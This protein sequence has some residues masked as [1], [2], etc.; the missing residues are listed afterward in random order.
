M[1]VGTDGVLLGAW[2]P[3][4]SEHVSK[5][6]VPT[7]LD[8]GTGS[9]LIALMLAQRCPGAHITAIDIN[10]ECAH[11][12]TLNFAASPWSKRLTAVCCPLSEWKPITSDNGTKDQRTI[13]DLQ[14][15]I[16]NSYDLIVSNPPYFTNSLPNPDAARR[17]ARHDDSLCLTDIM[18]F[19][20]RYLTTGGILSLVLPADA[21]QTAIANAGQHN[22][23]LYRLT[24]V[25]TRAGKQSKRILIAFSLSTPAQQSSITSCCAKV[26]HPVVDELCLQDS[27][28][29]RSEAYSTL[30]K[31]FY[32]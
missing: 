24:R 12:A 26:S 6:H 19:A 8:I 11:Q 14:S 10:N 22:L 28:A 30:T 21:E 32:L 17:T 31:D 15:S 23:R 9:G 18:S 27:D 3:L 4:P 25:C 1:K 7:V 2:T 5:D 20:Q 29:P 16:I 13:T